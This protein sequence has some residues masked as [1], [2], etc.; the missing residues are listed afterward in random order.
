MAIMIGCAF[1][2]DY[3]T[4]DSF[5]FCTVGAALF[6]LSDLALVVNGFIA[7]F[8]FSDATILSTYYAAQFCIVT[9]LLYA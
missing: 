1:N 4:S 8:P 3:T 5:P 7:K 2:L 6:A 9:G